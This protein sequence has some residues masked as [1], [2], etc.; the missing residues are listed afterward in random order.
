MRNWPTSGLAPA[1]TASALNGPGT[2]RAIISHSFEIGCS[3]SADGL[4]SCVSRKTTVRFDLDTLDRSSHTR[5]PC[6]RHGLASVSA[7]AAHDCSGQGGHQRRSTLMHM[8]AQPCELQSR[9]L[10]RGWAASHS[11]ASYSGTASPLRSTR[12]SVRQAPERRAVCSISMSTAASARSR[13]QACSRHSS[14]LSVPGEDAKRVVDKNG[15]VLFDSGD[16]TS[17]RPEVDRGTL[18][19]VLIR[20]LP[21]DT[22]RWGA[23]TR[24]HDGHWRWRA[25]TCLRKWRERRGRPGG[26]RGRRLVEGSTAP[27][28]CQAHLYGH[29]FRRDRAPERAVRATRQASR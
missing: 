26:G 8:G 7:N 28:E 15:N 4:T 3:D 23:Q 17:N 24:L 21:A 6:T 19:N 9:S 29:V 14:A 5:R 13:P 27:L 22:I 18:R 20:S 1:R 16:R 2:K 25:R 12:P 10:V 11:P